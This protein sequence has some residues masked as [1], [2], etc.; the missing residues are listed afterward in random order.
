VGISGHIRIGDKAMIA[1]RCGVTTSLEGGQTYSGHP[2]KLFRDDMKARAHV[3]R[4]P[5]LIERIKALENAMNPP[6]NRHD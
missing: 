4:L 1:A 3:R 5:K 6:S 2:A